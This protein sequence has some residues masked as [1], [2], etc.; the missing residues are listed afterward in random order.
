MV[1]EDEKP[2]L[3]KPESNAPM[4][5][6][7]VSA[8]AANVTVWLRLAAGMAQSLPAGGVRVTVTSWAF[9]VSPPRRRV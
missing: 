7:A 5:S 6:V 2:M 9:V 3:P 8:P 4:D 1:A